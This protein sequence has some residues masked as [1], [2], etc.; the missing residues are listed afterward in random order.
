MSLEDFQLLDNEPNDNSMTETVFTEIYQQQG[1][2]LV[3]SDKNIVFISGENNNHHQIGKGYLEFNITVRKKDITNFHHEDPVRLVNNGYAF[4]FKEA[5]LSTSFSS[6][7]EH[8]NFCGQRSTTMKVITRKDD[9]LLS[10]FGNVTENDI[11]ILE[12]LAIL[13]TQNKST[14]HQKMLIDNHID[15]KKGKSKR[16]LYLEDFFWVLHNF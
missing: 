16:Y 4:C 3:Q 7:I 13:P 1:A 15:A 6:D 5:R 10:Q 12:R 9:G 14:T 2:Q 11:P 8:N